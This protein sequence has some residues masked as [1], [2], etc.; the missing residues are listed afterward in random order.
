ME[1]YESKIK[2]VCNSANLV[3]SKLSNLKNLDNI[4]PRDK[5]QNWESTEDTCR[6]SVEKMPEMGV[7][8]AERQENSLIKYTADGSTPFNFN[9]WVQLKEVAPYESRIKVTMKVEL[10]MMMRMMVG[11]KLQEAVDKIAETLAVYPYQ[12][13]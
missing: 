12:Q 10:N 1:T 13:M 3:Y 4:V 11:S 2:V 9:L 6:F 5:I 8:I 7:R